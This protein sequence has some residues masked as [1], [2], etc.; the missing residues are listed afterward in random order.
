[1][2]LSRCITTAWRVRAVPGSKL[3]LCFLCL[4]GI[5]VA[6][7]PRLNPVGVEGLGVSALSPL[8]G[9]VGHDVAA[10][11]SLSGVK[12]LDGDVG[13][14]RGIASLARGV[15]VE[16]VPVF[17]T[18]RENVEALEVSSLPVVVRWDVWAPWA[19]MRDVQMSALEVAAESL[20]AGVRAVEPIRQARGSA[21]GWD[22]VPFQVGRHSAMGELRFAANA[23][24]ARGDFAEAERLR[25]EFWRIGGV[26]A[27]RREAFGN[28]P[29]P[30]RGGLGHGE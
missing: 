11:A 1:M 26:M 7:L 20:G 23:A 14:W 8:V 22:L 12:R 13:E 16:G 27:A 25:R 28:R 10:V 30:M 9:G 29:V 15:G 5:A 4:S 6:E 24:E 2:I 17:L 3:F 19:S 21:V 18:L